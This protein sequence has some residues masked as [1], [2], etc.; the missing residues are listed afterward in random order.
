MLLLEEGLPAETNYITLNLSFDIIATQLLLRT[1]FFF[2]RK[3][4]SL[5]ARATNRSYYVQY[6]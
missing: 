4:A 1:I 2:G 3:G 6:C 5:K